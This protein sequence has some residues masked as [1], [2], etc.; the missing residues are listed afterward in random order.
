MRNKSAPRTL[1]MPKTFRAGGFNWTLAPASS[2]NEMGPA[3]N[4]STTI[5]AHAI[6]VRDTGFESQM[7]QTV[8]H[9]LIHVADWLACSGL[10]EAQ[11][12][13]IEKGLWAIL[14]DN[15]ALILYLFQ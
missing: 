8:F 11:T 7:R 12:E 13:Q 1:P 4:G 15:P 10:T 14:N 6:L 9:E 2:H 3:Y 5:N